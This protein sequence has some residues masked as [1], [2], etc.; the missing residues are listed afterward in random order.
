MSKDQQIIL[1]KD[2]KAWDKP[3]M[4]WNEEGRQEE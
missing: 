2:I 3:R 1:E 4:M